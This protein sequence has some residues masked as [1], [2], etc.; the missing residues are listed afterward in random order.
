MYQFSD[1]FSFD[2]SEVYMKLQLT[3]EYDYKK[4]GIETGGGYS[5][6]RSSMAALY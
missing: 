5:P 1:I 4:N 2:A 3:R 6:T